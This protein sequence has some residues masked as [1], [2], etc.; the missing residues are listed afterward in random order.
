[1]KRRVG[2]GGL[3]DAAV[4]ARGRTRQDDGCKPAAG[5]AAKSVFGGPEDEALEKSALFRCLLESYGLPPDVV[6]GLCS[7]LVEMMGYRVAYD[8]ATSPWFV[9]L[10]YWRV[11]AEGAL[12]FLADSQAD[13]S[14]PLLFLEN[15]PVDPR[16]LLFNVTR[17]ALVQ[18]TAVINVGTTDEEKLHELE[19]QGWARR[20]GE[21]WGSNDCLADS[22]LQLLFENMV[23][24][25]PSVS[26]EELR[27]VRR[28]ACR[29]NRLLLRASDGLHPCDT[30]GRPDPGAYLQHDRHAHATVQFFLNRFGLGE[31]LPRAG[32]C[33][34]VHSRMDSDQIPP[35]TRTICE[36]VSDLPGPPLRLHLFNWTGRGWSG[37]HYDPLVCTGEHLAEIVSVGDEDVE[38]Q[39]VIL[40]SLNAVKGSSDAVS[41]GTVQPPVPTSPALSLGEVVVEGV[42][43]QG[44]ELSGSLGVDASGGADQRTDRE[45]ARSV[46]SLGRQLS[47][48]SLEGEEAQG[49]EKRRRTGRLLRLARRETDAPDPDAA[50]F[51]GRLSRQGALHS[52]ADVAMRPTGTLPSPNVASRLQRAGF[53]DAPQGDSEAGPRSLLRR[54]RGAGR[55]TLSERPATGQTSTAGRR[56]GVI[57]TGFDSERIDDVAADETRRIAEGARRGDQRR[58]EGTRG[59]LTDRTGADLDRG[60]GG[61]WHAGRRR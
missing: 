47:E 50:L 35:A 17:L 48:L 19:Q 27:K 56:H 1:M 26:D 16:E 15:S 61:A 6:T 45:A 8:L 51:A 41:S 38:E 24:L 20:D 12:L 22:L 14:M 52:D 11:F 4:G 23:V 18:E 59:R 55:G 58:R 40:A 44:Q 37:F 54:R 21:A 3:A 57:V 34:V 31:S 39:G 25:L 33:L 13:F 29:E 60:E 49:D 36:G 28:D 32:I 5:A 10:E 43:A 46:R 2:T 7:G 9:E 53:G 42:S 30:S